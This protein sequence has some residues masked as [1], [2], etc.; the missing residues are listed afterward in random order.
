MHGAAVFYG[1]VKKGTCEISEANRKEQCVMA[2]HTHY[3]VNTT[4]G[5]SG[6]PETRKS[7]LLFDGKAILP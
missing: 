3:S 4:S 5:P 1:F 2:N 6:Y 7:F